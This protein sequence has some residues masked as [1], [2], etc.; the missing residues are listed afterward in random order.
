MRAPS[1]AA[2]GLLGNV[3]ALRDDPLQFWLD[4]RKACGPVAR[5]RL[6]PYLGHL[7]SEPEHI[8]HVL[9]DHHRNYDRA[10]RQFDLISLA[11]GNGLLTTSGDAWLQRRRLVQPA[12]HR[13][14]IAALEQAMRSIVDEQLDRLPLGS[15]LDLAHFAFDLSFDVILRTMFSADAGISR[16]DIAQGVEGMTAYVD[17]AMTAAFTW[18]LG[19]PTPANRR[20]LRARRNVDDVICKLIDAH[21]ASGRRG[22]DILSFLLDVRDEA[23]GEALPTDELCDQVKTILLAGHETVANAL[24]WTVHLLGSRPDVARALKADAPLG[25]RVLKEA[26]RLYPPGWLIGR[27]A[28]EADVVGGFGIPKGSMVFVVPYVTHRLEAYWPEPERFDPSRFLPEAEAKRPRHAWLPF[29]AGPH[30][31]IGQGFAMLELQLMLSALVRR[32]D[33]TPIAPALPSPR[34]TLGTR[35]GLPVTLAAA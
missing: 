14:R 29:G 11:L 24:T 34:I 35:G 33:V 7:I 25:T 30:V 20:F 18:P 31:C 27:N 28:V 23:T 12:F 13:Q 5:L 6:G 15:P 9:V 3:R 4:A 19:I 1:Y 17:R 21:R 2:P 8:K 32:F 10:T 22:D 26:M 16:D